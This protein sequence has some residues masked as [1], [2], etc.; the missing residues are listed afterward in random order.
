MSTP[1]SSSYAV[2]W[3]QTFKLLGITLNAAADTHNINLEEKIKQIMDEMV[4]WRTRFLSPIGRKNVVCS[5]FLSKMT[6]IATVLPVLP[7]KD[8][9]KL[10]RDVYD[11]IWAGFP[12]MNRPEAKMALEH[13]GLQT[14]DIKMQWACN[15]IGWNRRL[16]LNPD[17][18][19][20]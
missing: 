8:I 9:A 10:E 17:T 2:T 4:H 20:A 13:G 18:K 7:A 16:D 12:K 6:H 19:W 15:K 1:H 3:D 5:L 11:F 14:P